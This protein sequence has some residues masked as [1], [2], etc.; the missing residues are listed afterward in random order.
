MASTSTQWILE[1]VD[2]ISSPIKNIDASIDKASNNARTMAVN[3][4][5]I[6]NSFRSLKNRLNEAVAPGIQFQD[7]LADVEAI[8]GVTGKAL[9]NLGVKARE[10]A[11]EFGGDATQSLTNYKT[12]LSRLGPDIAKDQDALNLMNQNVLTL[13]KTMGNDAVG[14]VDALTTAMLQ[15]GVDLSDPMQAAQD[16]KTMMNIMAAGAKEGAAEVTDV[17]AALKASG[18]QASQ[19]NLSFGETNAAIQELAKGGKTGSEAGI[20]LRNV[21]GKM[22]GADVIP[23]EALEKLSSYGV[24]MDIVSDKSIPFTERLRELSKAQGDSTAMAQVFGVENASAAA[25]LLRSVDA[26]DS[27]K[28]KIIGTNTAE[29]QAAVK[30]D[31]YSEKASRM[32]AWVKDLGISVFNSTQNFLPFINTGFGA[33]DVLADLKNAQ[34]G[35]SM[36]M[37]TK[38][39]KG[40]KNMGTGLKTALGWSKAMSISIFKQIGHVA[41]LG[42]SYLISGASILGGWVSSLITATAAQLG[43][44]VAM[45]ANPIGLIILGIAAAIAA[46][47]VM[48]K[49]WD[50]IKAVIWK[51][52][53]FIWKYSPFNFIIELVEK[54]FPGFKEKISKVFE[55]VKNL[56]LGFWN[57]IKEV[58]GDIKKFFGFGE[59]TSV[60]ATVTV[61]GGGEDITGGGPS[62]GEILGSTPGTGTNTGTTGGGSSTGGSGGGK[63]IT[64]TLD[65]KNYFNVGADFKGKIDEIA[66]LV[67]G[68]IND[69]LKDAVISVG[70]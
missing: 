47:V 40:L 58:W 41:S 6:A 42:V 61:T 43:L 18:V 44:N 5:S 60:T 57:K 56:V 46:I 45:M 49:Y 54:I 48:V 67:V 19:S 35:L 32:S 8:T 4:E 50:E 7:G 33:V 1:L 9:E 16:M 26:Q 15:Y 69:K 37:D 30:M 21:L 53:Q 29:E 62:T 24:N 36:V 39:G 3:V 10:S 17:A 14:S 12:L 63:N 2:K 70:S 55:Y 31:T 34:E 20:A 59:Q 13:S 38:L 25:I 52:I 68:R 28:E 23:K 66:D 27:L 65:V 64:M 11:K 22:A 51:F